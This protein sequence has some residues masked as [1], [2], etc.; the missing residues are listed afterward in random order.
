MPMTPGFEPADS[1]Y[2]H[3]R[4]LM[5][6]ANL[7]DPSGAETLRAYYQLDSVDPETELF[8]PK[9]GKY[10]P[11]TGEGRHD[12]KHITN[13]YRENGKPTA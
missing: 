1:E 6:P 10:N 3:G 9:T 5:P 7:A 2:S 8:K 4:G 11:L 12:D 13:P